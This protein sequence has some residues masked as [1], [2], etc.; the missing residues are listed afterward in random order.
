MQRLRLTPLATCLALACALPACGDD[1]GNGD[2]TDETGDGDGDP[3]DGDPGDGDP[4]DGDPGDGD[5]GDGDPGDGDPGDGD[6]GD[7]DPGDGDP[8][9]GDPGDGDPGDGDPGEELSF[10]ADVYPIIMANC[11]CHLFGPP[12]AGLSMANVDTAYTNLVGVASTQQ[13][14]LLRVE[15]GN[16]DDSYLYQKITGT[17]ADPGP[18]NQQMPTAVPLSADDIMTVADW[19]A[20]GAA[21]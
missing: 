19:I 20:G 7:G 5:P 10:A 8:G 13:P 6:P 16:V 17:Q 2:V 21:P 4:G 15:P 11:S 18:L 14:S 3:G 12:P 1:D 9:D